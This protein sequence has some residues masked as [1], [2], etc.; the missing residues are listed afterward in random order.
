[1]RLAAIILAVILISP[2]ASWS[3]MAGP[4]NRVQS[5]PQR[6]DKSFFIERQKKRQ[7]QLQ[8][9]KK[10]VRP[11]AKG[12]KQVRSRAQGKGQPAKKGRIPA[13][14][15]TPSGQ[16]PIRSGPLGPGGK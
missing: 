13:R 7:Q 8:N 16:Q 11:A 14:R 1:M 2:G 10:Q 15:G 6:A 4:G 9:R 5:G 12:K 3:Q